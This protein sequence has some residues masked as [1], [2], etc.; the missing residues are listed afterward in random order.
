MAPEQ[1]RGEDIDARADIYGLGC[2]SLLPADRD[3]SLQ[4]AGRPGHGR[5]APH[6]ATR[7][8]FD[9]LGVAGSA[10]P[11]ARRDGLSGKEPREPAAVCGRA[12]DDAGQLHRLRTLDCQRRDSLVG[13]APARAGSKGVVMSAR[14]SNPVRHGDGGFGPDDGASSC[15]QGVARRHLPLAVLNDKSARDG[16]RGGDRL[17][18]RQHRGEPDSGT[19]GPAADAAAGIHPEQ[20]AAIRGV[21]AAWLER[22]SRGLRDLPAHGR[23]RCGADIRVLVAHGRVVR[24]AIGERVVRPHQ[25]N[26]NGGRPLRGAAR[27]ARGRLVRSKG[28]SAAAGRSAPG[29]RGPDVAGRALCRPASARA[30]AGA[31]RHRCGATLPVSAYVGRPRRPGIDWG[32]A[33]GFRLQGAGCAY[34]S[35]TARRCSGSSASTIRQPAC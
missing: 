8:A 6:R 1:V 18:R 21:A 12:S 34:A 25:R 32:G 4:Q 19:V 9:A 3:G 16:H 13:V 23:V 15:R 14:R 33:A 31:Q 24:S 11:R 27:R 35:G 5:V 30:G 10:I 17:N 29:L 7:A 20:H 2:L 28:S 22:A 26:G